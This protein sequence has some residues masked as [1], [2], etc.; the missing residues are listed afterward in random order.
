M[1]KERKEYKDR[2]TAPLVNE[3]T[4]E[5]GSKT[6]CRECGMPL[7]MFDFLES[8]VATTCFDCYRENYR[9]GK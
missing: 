8:T 9:K 7:D 5:K 6:E 2:W 1:K 4:T 3:P